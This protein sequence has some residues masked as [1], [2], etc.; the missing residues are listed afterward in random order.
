M[1]NLG[2]FKAVSI[3]TNQWIEGYL[4]RSPDYTSISRI[5]KIDNNGVLIKAED[6][7]T[8]TISEC[9]LWDNDDNMQIFFNGDIVEFTNG[10][11]YGLLIFDTF[12]RAYKVFYVKDKVV[13]QMNA[14]SL[15]KVF[16]QSGMHVT[17][18]DLPKDILPLQ[19]KWSNSIHQR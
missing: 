5:L 4:V 17:D 19:H 11:G 9:A 14:L 12:E 3:A 15:Q 8:K 6:V 1:R 13:C 7:I 10:R 2:L 16:R 18:F